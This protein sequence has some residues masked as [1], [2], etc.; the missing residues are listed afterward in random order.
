MKQRR[1][2]LLLGMVEDKVYSR[3]EGLNTQKHLEESRL[4]MASKLSQAMQQENQE[5]RSREKRLEH[6]N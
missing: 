3:F 4:N 5:G 1:T 2:W 6:I